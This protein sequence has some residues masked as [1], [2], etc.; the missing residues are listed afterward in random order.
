MSYQG[1]RLPTLNDGHDAAPIGPIAPADD[2]AI[3]ALPRQRRFGDDQ[4]QLDP[5]VLAVAAA[6]QAELLGDLD[7]LFD[8]PRTGRSDSHQLRRARPPKDQ[9]GRHEAEQSGHVE[10]PA[11]HGSPLFGDRD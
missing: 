9:S 2:Q 10:L 4:A 11:V 3:D 5:A 8:L 7:D 6:V 1:E